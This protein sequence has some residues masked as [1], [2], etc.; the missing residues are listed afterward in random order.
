MHIHI[1]L[2]TCMHIIILHTCTHIILHTWKHTHHN[3]H[4]QAHIIW[5]M[6]MCTHIILYACTQH[7]SNHTCTHTHHSAH[8]HMHTQHMSYCTHAQVKDM[9]QIVC[10]R[11]KISIPFEHWIFESFF[12]CERQITHTLL[13]HISWPFQFWEDFPKFSILT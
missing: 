7:I 10:L 2:H 12:I 3:A 8:M 1:I 6:C 13:N 11:T 4:M 5:H 9:E